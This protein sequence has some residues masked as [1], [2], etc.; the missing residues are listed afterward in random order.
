MGI[1]SSD[2]YSQGES[3][4]AHFKALMD[5][6]PSEFLF[7]SRLEQLTVFNVFW[8]CDSSAMAGRKT[9][10]GEC[11]HERGLHLPSY[12]VPCASSERR[13]KA[14]PSLVLLIC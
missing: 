9:A 1:H 10:T 14:T 11:E 6:C 12:G 3:W 2:P 13:E 8:L 4:C 5:I 7:V